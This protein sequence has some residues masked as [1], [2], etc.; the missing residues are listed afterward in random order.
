MDIAI[1]GV[2]CKFPEAISPD[3]YWK[4]LTSKRSCIS[5]I[6]VSR[7][8][9][10]EYWGDPKK[11][12]NKS[13]SKWAGFI[14]GV[15]KFDANFFGLLPKVVSTM[16]PQ[17]RI[18]LELAWECLENA[19]IAP[20]TLRGSRTGVFCGVFNHDYKELQEGQRINIEAHHSTGTASS[21]IAN[22]ISHYFDFKGPSFPIDTAC[23]SSLNAVHSAIQAIE[24]GDCDLA[25]A[26]GVNLILTPTRHIS[27]SKMG[28]L[29]PT[30]RCSTFDDSAD[31]Y[32]RGEGAGFLLMKPLTQ[33]LADGDII[34]CVIKGSAV[35]HC[36]E[37]YTLT[38][39][40]AEAQADVI[41]DAHRRANVPL[42]SVSYVETHGTGTPKG[43]PIEI[44]GLKLAFDRMAKEQKID[45]SE[46]ECHLSAVKTNIGHLE[47]AAGVAGIIKVIQSF[48][49]RELAPLQNYQALNSRIRLDDTPFK[50]VKDATNW[51]K[52]VKN[53]QISAPLRAGIS[54]FGFGGTNAHIVLEQPP[55][56]KIK[57]QAQHSHYLV[58]VSAKTKDSLFS[59]KNKLKDWIGN[60][61]RKARMQDICAGLAI[62]RDHLNVRSAYVVK[63]HSDLLTA[64]HKDID[65]GV[66]HCRQIN[67]DDVEVFEYSSKKATAFIDA[68]LSAT[69]KNRNIEKLYGVLLE[70]YLQG[71]KWDFCKLFPTKKTQRIQ[72][73]T[74]AFEKNSYWI[75]E[76]NRQGFSAGAMLHPLVHENTS[77]LEEQRFTSHFTGREFFLKDHI[78]QGNKVLPAAAYLEIIC[79][80]L[81]RSAE[82]GEVDKSTIEI[83]DMVFLKPLVGRDE[84]SE[85]RVKIFPSQP[86]FSLPENSTYITFE[87]ASGFE[88]SIIDINCHGSALLSEGVR[89]NDPIEGFWTDTPKQFKKEEI[90]VLLTQLGFS[91][92][93][94]HQS[95]V[96]LNLS[97]DAALAELSLPDS[98]GE[99]DNQYRIHPSIIDGGLQSAVVLLSEICQEEKSDAKTILP[100]SIDRVIVSE[101]LLKSCFSLIK[102]QDVSGK[103]GVKKVDILFFNSNP[104]EGMAIPSVV[105]QGLNCR[106]ALLTARS[107]SD[108]VRDN[109]DKESSDEE[110]F[111]WSQPNKNSYYVPVWSAIDKAASKIPIAKYLLV[112]G[113]EER[114]ERCVK[115]L[116]CNEG[117]S[118]STFVSV[119][120]GKELKII[121]NTEFCVR[122]LEFDD[123][124]AVFKRLKEHGTLPEQVI[125][126]HDD[127][128]CLSPDRTDI[129]S[130]TAIVESV[131]LLVKAA[132]KPLRKMKILSVAKGD[133]RTA[134][135]LIQG[136]SGFYKSIKLE[137][138]TYSGRVLLLDELD[139][140]SQSFANIVKD[141][142]GFDDTRVDLAYIKDERYG[143]QFVTFNDFSKVNELVK[144]ETGCGFKSGGTYLVTGG[145]GALGILVAKHLISNYQADIYLTGR[146]ELTP[147]KMALLT[148][149]C[150]SGGSVTYLRGDVAEIDT[151]NNWID[152][153]NQSGKWINGVIHSAGVIEDNFVIK[154]EYS[155]FQR[156]LA[157]KVKGTVAL[158]VAT[159]DQPID[160]FVLF[161]SVTGI[162]GNLGQSDYGYGNSFEDYYSH[163]RNVLSE[164]GQRNGSAVSINWP[165]WKDGGMQLGDKEEEILFKNF[166][167]TPLENAAGLEALEFAVNLPIGQM[168]VLEGDQEKV[169]KVLGVT[170]LFESQETQTL[171]SSKEMGVSSAGVV[172]K[173]TIYAYLVDIFAKEL[174]ISKERFDL[175]S[176]FQTFGFDSVVMIDMVNVLEKE[177][178]GLPR[179]LF[180]ENQ[181][182][183][184]L[185]E[186]LLSEY[187]QNFSDVLSNASRPTISKNS[188][189]GYN[190]PTLA[191]SARFTTQ[192][193]TP[194]SESLSMDKDIAVVGISGRF[195]E[196]ENVTEF[197][198]NLKT[199]RD[200]ISEIP[201]DRG[202]NI[203]KLFSDG[204][205]KVGKTYSKWGGFLSGVDQFDPLFFNI[206]PKEA[207]EL[208]PH[209]RLFLE[210][211]FLAILDAG[212]RP[213]QLV[214]PRDL[215]DSPVGVYAGV[216]WGDYHLFGID[217]GSPGTLNTPQSYYW[218]V[219]NRV[220]YQFNFSGPSITID[221]ACSS[222]ITAMHLAIDALR[223]GE[224]DA[225]VAGGVNLSLHPAKYALLSNRR[226]LSTDGRC[227]SFGVGGD[228][229]VP[230]EAVGAVILK[231]KADAIRDGDHIYGIIK[232]TAINHG[233]KTSGFTVPNPNR[234]AA[235]IKNAIKTAGID[236]RDISYVEAHG[237][238]TSLG[239][240]IE[241]SG[242]TKAFEQNDSQFCAI[243]SAKSNIGHAE[244]AAGVAGLIKLLM[245]LKHKQIAPSLHSEDLNPYAKIDS[246][247]FVVQQTLGDWTVNN[248]KN[249]LAALSSFGAGGANG[250][251]ILEEYVA[252][253][254]PLTGNSDP[255]LIVLSARNELS[256]K[257]LVAEHADHI[258]RESNLVLEQI[259]FT[260]QTGRVAYDY[261]CALIV[262]SVAEL[263][264]LLE[265]VSVGK[266]PKNILWGKRES[267]G[268]IKGDPAAVDIEVGAQK[269]DLLKIASHWMTGSDIPWELLYSTKIRKISLPG[270]VFDKSRY[271]VKHTPLGT[272]AVEALSPLIDKN[273]STFD[274][275]CFEKTFH[276]NESYLMDHRVGDS[277]VLP[278][279]GYVEMVLQAARQASRSVVLGFENIQWLKPIIVD[280][281][282]STIRTGLYIDND[283]VSFEIFGADD[284]RELYCS[285]KLIIEGL[286][287]AGK[288]KSFSVPIE[289]PSVEQLISTGTEIDR[290]EVNSAFDRLGFNFG[291]T[292]RVIEKIV[293]S[294]T[295]SYSEIRLSA[296]D[297]SENSERFYLYPALLDGAI[298]TSVAIGGFNLNSGIP[299][300]VS[301]DK[302]VVRKPLVGGCKV[303]ARKLPINSNQNLRSRY[304]IFLLDSSGDVIVSFYGFTVQYVVKLA[305]T[306]NK[307][308]VAQLPKSALENKKTISLPVGNSESNGSIDKYLKSLV[309]DATKVS[310][311]EI[312]SSDA[313]DAYGI[314]SVMIMAMNETLRADFGDEIPQTLFFEYQSIDE[315]KEF[316]EENYNEHFRSIIKSPATDAV[317]AIQVIENKN[318]PP[319][320]DSKIAITN[321]LKEALSSATKLP[322]NAIDI[323]E[324]LDKYGVDSVMITSMNDQISQVFGNDVP[325]TLFYEF[326]EIS[327]ISEYFLENHEKDIIRKLMVLTD[328]SV[329]VVSPVGNSEHFVDSDIEQ[330]SEKV[331]SEKSLDIFNIFSG[332]LSLIE[333]DDILDE[334]LSHL[335]I[336]AVSAMHIEAKLG[337]LY[338]EF[339]GKKLSIYGSI[340][341]CI[342]RLSGDKLSFP[343]V[344]FAPDSSSKKVQSTTS[345][346]VRTSIARNKPKARHRFAISSSSEPIAVIGLAGRYPQANT[347]EE[348]W[349]NLCL[350]KDSIVDVPKDRWDFRTS[351]T[352]DRTKKGK[353]YS[354]WGGFLD[355][356]DQFDPEFFRITMREAEKID[357][358]ER[359]FL[360]TSWEC[361]EDAGI[362]RIALKGSS[363]GVFVGV[364]WG[365]YQHIPISEQQLKFGKPASSF[366]SIAN[367]VSYTFDLKGPSIALDTMCS[368]SITAIQIACQNIRNGDCEIAVAGGVNLATHA[369]KY[370]LLS[371]EQFLSSDG[372]CRAFGEGGTG[373]VPG[374]GAGAV[375]LKPLSKAIEDG[376]NIYGVIHATALNH[377]GKTN[378]YTVP[379]QKAQ[380]AVIAK[381]LARAN[382]RADSLSYIEAHGTGTSLGDPIEVAG[383]TRAL[384]DS[385]EHGLSNISKIDIGSVKTNI[386]HLESAAGIA[387][388]TKILLQ[389]KNKKIVPSLHSRELS[390][391]I[392]F[393]STPLN[394][395]QIL[396][397]WENKL[398]TPRRAALSS[399][400]AGGSNAHILVEEF[401]DIE[402]PLDESVHKVVFV[403]SAD[404]QARLTLYV[405]RVLGWL[406]DLETKDVHLLH[407]LAFSSQIGRDQ[408]ASRLAVVTDSVDELISALS[409]FIEKSDHASLVLNHAESNIGL[410][411]LFD[412]EDRN[413]LLEGILA[414]SQWEKLAA[415]W[416][417]SIDVDWASYTN[418]LF[419]LVQQFGRQYLKKM[420]FPPKPYLEQRV[421]V[422]E[423]KKSEVKLDPIHPLIDRNHSSIFSQ[424]YSKTFTGKEF[425]LSDHVVNT[426]DA[427]IILPGVAYLEIARVCGE[428]AVLGE[429][430]IKHIQNLLW[431]SPIEVRGEPIEI[432]V[433]IRPD[434]AE[435]NFDIRSSDTANTIH[436]QGTLLIG[437]DEFQDDEWLDI[438]ALV[439]S[440]HT[441]ENRDDIYN[442]FFSMG[443]EYGPSYR[444]T[445][446]RYRFD[447]KQALSE[448]V[449]S[450]THESTLQDFVLHP[451][452]MDAA[453]RTGL[454]ADY[455]V[456]HTPS[457]PIVPFGVEHVEI[458]HPLEKHCFAFAYMDEE[459]SGS[460]LK[461]Y[462]I[463]IANSQGKVLVKLHNFSA[464][465][466]VK[467][468]PDIIDDVNI[469]D[470]FWKR[471]DAS[472]QDSSRIRESVLLFDFDRDLAQ[473]MK[474]KCDRGVIDVSISDD[475]YFGKSDDGST[476]YWRINAGDYSANTQ[477][478]SALKRKN[479][480]PSVIFFQAKGE[481]G[482][483]GNGN[484]GV[485]NEVEKLAHLLKAIEEIHPLQP[486]KLVCFHEISDPNKNSING[487]LTG[488][489]KSLL[490]INHRFKMV[491][492]CFP[493]SIDS[494]TRSS[495]LISEYLDGNN[496]SEEVRYLNDERE[497]RR[498]QVSTKS[499]RDNVLKFNGTYMITG[500]MGKLGLVFARYLVDT[501]QANLLL[502]GR[503][504][505]TNEK[506]L[507]VDTL[508]SENNHVEYVSANTSD[509]KEVNGLIDHALKTFGSLNGVIHSAGVSDAKSLTEQGVEE[510][511]RVLEPKVTGTLILDE[512]TKRINLDFF[513]L[514]SSISA[515]VG[516]LG[517]G[518]YACAN[519]FMD[520][521]AEHRQQKVV[522]GERN[523]LTL[524]IN[525]PLWLEGGM[526]IPKE[527]KA[528]FE[529]SGI[530]ALGEVQG[531][532][533][534][535]SLLS[536]GL[537][538]AVVA[539]GDSQKLKGYLKVVG[540]VARADKVVEKRIIV[541]D[542]GNTIQMKRTVSVPESLKTGIKDPIAETK[543][544]DLNEFLKNAVSSV[545]K[546]VS[547]KIDINTRFEG[548]GLDSVMLMELQNQLQ[549]TFET[550]PKTALFEHDTVARLA[551]FISSQYSD[552]VISLFGQNAKP[553]QIRATYEEPKP[554]KKI[555]GLVKP[556]GAY[557]PLPKRVEKASEDIAVIG[558][559]A[560]FPKANNLEEFW[561]ILCSGDSTI[562]EIP[563]TR[564]A[565]EDFYGTQV[566]RV[567]D[568]AVSKWGSFID[569]IDEF[570]HDLFNMTFDEVCKLDPQVK[571]LLEAAWC[572]FEDAAYTPN[573]FGDDRV[574]VFIGSMSDD[575][576]R[577]VAD[578]WNEKKQYFGPGS[579]GSEL[580]NRISYFFDL[581]GP[582]MSIQTACSSS[583]TAI[584]LARNAILNGEC[585]YALAGGVSVSLHP[586]KYL[587]L[588]DMKV[589]SP[590]GREATF[591]EH[592]NGLV[593]S[594]GAGLILLKRYDDA[595]KDGDNIYG[596]IKASSV[597]HAGVGAGQFLPNLRDMARTAADAIEA[598]GIT[599]EHIS[600]IECHG[601]GTELGDPIELKAMELAIAKTTEAKGFCALGTK[602]NLGHMEAASGVCSVIKVLL[603]MKH[604]TI[605]PCVNIKEANTVFEKDLSPFYIPMRA[606]SWRM[607]ELQPV[608][609]GINSFGMGGA[610]TFMVLESYSHSEMDI[611]SDPEQAIVFSAK[612]HEQLVR[613]V[614]NVKTYLQGDVIYNLQDVAFTTQVGRAAMVYRVAFIVDNVQTFIGKA[615]KWVG[616]TEKELPGVIIGDPKN[617]STTSFTELLSDQSGELYINSLMLNRQLQALVSLWVMGAQIDWN[618]FHSHGNPKR[619]SLPNY[620]WNRVNTHLSNYS[621][622]V[623]TAEGK[624]KE[625]ILH[626][627]VSKEG[628]YDSW[629]IIDKSNIDIAGLVVGE[630]GRL[631]GKI[632]GKDDWKKR[633]WKEYLN[634]FQS[635]NELG[636]LY[637]C[638]KFGNISEANI[639]ELSAE[640]ITVLKMFC[641][642]NQI[643]L[644]TLFIG[645]WG[646][647]LS[648]LSSNKFSQLAHGLSTGSVNVLLP[649]RIPC[650]VR[651]TAS[652]W[653]RVIQTERLIKYVA[654]EEFNEFFA[655]RKHQETH[656]S[657]LT[658]NTHE[659]T[660]PMMKELKLEAAA[661]ISYFENKAKITLYCH[662]NGYMGQSSENILQ[663]LLGFI[664]GIA[665]NPERNPAA[666]PLQLP[667]DKKKKTFMRI[668]DREGEGKR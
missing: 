119:S 494:I 32:V 503:S 68:H 408:L 582:S 257:G 631:G 62:G 157:P 307:S 608:A 53:S 234:Q 441:V 58:L 209:E 629:F 355:S 273:I 606:T 308:S 155:A 639:Q 158:D 635:Q 339:L 231:R 431:I 564:W 626:K 329:N 579:V 352:E 178:E 425:Y 512:A 164:N 303:F 194:L 500:G 424:R 528:F 414:K 103:N 156:V 459:S 109:G 605:S 55:E 508:R 511:S 10:K 102:I 430:P 624:G 535:E 287:P 277:R 617:K 179:T 85:M 288:E 467:I 171:A 275:Q 48:K 338:P 409:A 81:I 361:F 80:T 590:N 197:W 557:Q 517:S 537:T 72:L 83:R 641:A 279:V 359:L 462:Q 315:L 378:G 200:S 235:L 464:R 20:S 276:P 274:E 95:I 258:K 326:Q 270:Y 142:L 111:H 520:M 54:S 373:Y 545:T 169:K 521:F 217:G 477:L 509:P 364:M 667:G 41:C 622:F 302:I 342:E 121:S 647:L 293:Y 371:Q 663:Y 444:V 611:H 413:K 576:S 330:S 654:F 104:F 64:L 159:K 321:F 560:R 598:S 556:L 398:L 42:S 368:S 358:Q 60:D 496:M 387:G 294:E 618:K 616:N 15:D 141:E 74:Y 519:R 281:D 4:N 229:Y 439:D 177:F 225:G 581:H 59:A 193:R 50:I 587:M 249:R 562:S 423:A 195:P 71:A 192:N 573:S 497:V 652:E 331:S 426:G 337:A 152:Q 385:V 402:F 661:D 578:S 172:S 653:L 291:E 551:E 245:Q 527:Q 183:N 191:R 144:P 122:A 312:D 242:L 256:L 566:G 655:D 427:R 487:A 592:A 479:A 251:L 49:N 555:N 550:L 120:T 457:H 510:F 135:S 240:P 466:F 478:V 117:F 167:I 597:S 640:E 147:E 126:L 526:E 129:L 125:I 574:G 215:Y 89:G 1:I 417:S 428:Q 221:T 416:V 366:S 36:G 45:L 188:T 634:E 538:N 13:L 148:G 458:I 546:V 246:S 403:L 228:G 150:E 198:N 250:H 664:I 151:V 77:S 187:G 113:G 610:N 407:R 379:N 82:A 422:D 602:A 290:S 65:L 300:P 604:R 133:H 244:A 548:L 549:S 163:Y 390:R 596:L 542:E 185:S 435:L 530:Q 86:T 297:K 108:C 70:L 124:D 57:R 443:F 553:K 3:Q 588:Q 318:T 306:K 5:E 39:P 357:P 552:S 450:D 348:F 609:A 659:L 30:G 132:F 498:L 614:D 347:L 656:N 662:E 255:K 374:E 660:L 131:F 533:A 453:V 504:A 572:T 46:L 254:L 354:K 539:A 369:I 336:D 607:N 260:L 502:T 263:S 591:D 505:L 395:P 489:S 565:A 236:P 328:A 93:V 91:Y 343:K 241:V 645:A 569:D 644:E 570:D 384:N 216:M 440:A 460:E 594:E 11:G 211:V 400:G 29:S 437:G 583:S 353:I 123:Y 27:F 620:P 613:Y 114:I 149:L 480:F 237:T 365:L 165:Y 381:A 283:S 476:H 619:V 541:N 372:R 166:G 646:L 107:E 79:E 16:D 334:S 130:L 322:I 110:L 386:G 415:V 643:E 405:E 267:R 295:E 637:S 84:H 448:L 189:L 600:Y 88:N 40:S 248:G 239:D 568:K 623:A 419:P 227:R 446:R 180:F 18:S 51:Q 333:A 475:S 603:S 482:A 612:T 349:N 61:G 438:D 140:Q 19:C 170:S 492:V 292:F 636:D 206:S 344:S 272:N 638:S 92:G 139:L 247:P 278:G 532:K 543:N 628:V 632:F 625:D 350:G 320:S 222:S 22:R 305:G 301:V 485:S 418:V 412:E 212:Y 399:F 238:G 199:G 316:F 115:A 452:I 451:C 575:F 513:V 34:Q 377:G 233:G 389:L 137:K 630:G 76:G 218:A 224:I 442:E 265:Q 310:L 196:A 558:I 262:E 483:P 580:A 25:L 96:K 304:D 486:F 436:C 666:V 9:W 162:F 271:W 534:F 186:Y 31:G 351:F 243:G 160:V 432:E 269:P 26:G 540:G 633:Y 392:N 118:G 383:L 98:I 559:G 175:T 314:D 491:S 7:W 529:F 127:F 44:E 154:K 561:E 28:M 69:A 182:L 161:S 38:Y 285:G 21:I 420:S 471:E 173:N 434:E 6:P 210:T 449:L 465:S 421:W 433:H 651:S 454:A 106:E 128:D 289:T 313:L 181:N 382:W 226:F 474:E 648:R 525:W 394:V 219:A 396:K 14:D 116:S 17:Q 261:G 73:P 595:L 518:S 23:S 463:V 601:T 138:P 143:R 495:I 67:I 204:S 201:E 223:K 99:I 12:D 393:D 481:L 105:I 376:D 627:N 536:L 259:A 284:G 2:A 375:L 455:A 75:P 531:L 232:S 341:E 391:N 584:H 370:E 515:L 335:S 203:E 202:W 406:C 52:L 90:Y 340:N 208:D 299:L 650:V 380:T 571:L 658:F 554:A 100:F 153:I 286:S 230:A 668:L 404:D 501:Y 363:V 356:V 298:R 589:L 327:S 311:N 499:L 493:A 317:D 280:D 176:N 388:L 33:A 567:V 516:D 411:K 401:E 214:K 346:R 615:E 544:D 47:A 253:P 205:P 473:E 563:D 585:R 599:A 56:K 397:E 360:Q 8:D 319:G 207:E 190:E 461:K 282:A 268:N 134:S 621:G 488:F 665:T 24:Y 184:D 469:Y 522:A 220:S 325:K 213:E 468:G 445:Q 506:Q 145:L 266:T 547:E 324:A 523:G 410:N 345:D 112:V 362:N 66:D 470:Y 484:R 657:L 174:K 296:N 490:A 429:Y 35:N 642:D 593:P 252:E 514:F 649:F 94:S 332:E 97:S 447:A 78:V 63:N 524:S 367:R 323:D 168:A 507:I 264:L 101:R 146:S 43:D 87:V 309:S 577:V 472:V 136:L 586:S 456:G 37:T